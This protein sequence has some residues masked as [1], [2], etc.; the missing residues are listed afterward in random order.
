MNLA[1]ITDDHAGCGAWS[2]GEGWIV[3]YFFYF[4]NSH[5]RPIFFLFDFNQSIRIIMTDQRKLGEHEANLHW[6]RKKN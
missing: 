2:R 1:A 4:R 6:K 5:I 3:I